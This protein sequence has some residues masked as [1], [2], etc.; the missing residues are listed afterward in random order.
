MALHGSSASY[1]FERFEYLLLVCG[2]DCKDRVLDLTT[3]D[4]NVSRR[5]DQ[6]QEWL[7]DHPKVTHHAILDDLNLPFIGLNFYKIDPA[8]GLRME[9]T[10]HIVD[11]LR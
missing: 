7:E 3:T 10:K 1:D 8:K 11:F 5:D 4:E 2:V 9:D 6:I